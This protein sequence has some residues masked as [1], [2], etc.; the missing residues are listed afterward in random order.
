MIDPPDE[1]GNLYGK[2][3]GANWFYEP[4]HTRR[5]LVKELAGEEF[6]TGYATLFS[7]IG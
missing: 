7:R 3:G 2:S 6:R 4:G 5:V 1:I